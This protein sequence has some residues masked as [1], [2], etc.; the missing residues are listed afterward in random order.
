M[1][2]TDQFTDR[3]GKYLDKL[4]RTKTFLA[5][6]SDIAKNYLTTNVFLWQNPIQAPHTLLV[7]RL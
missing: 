6:F 7:S 3:E 1:N 4:V 2:C 5:D